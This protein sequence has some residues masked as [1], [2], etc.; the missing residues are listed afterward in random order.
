M[1]ELYMLENLKGEVVW[2][3]DDNPLVWTDLKIAEKQADRRK[4]S[5]AVLADAVAASSH[6]KNSGHREL[7]KMP[8]GAVSL[9]DMKGHLLRGTKL[10]PGEPDE[11]DL[12]DAPKT[13]KEDD[14]KF[15]ISM[16]EGAGK[17]VD[18]RNSTDK[19]KK[20]LEDHQ[21]NEESQRQARRDKDDE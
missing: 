19:L 7:E 15:I 13:A 4:C 3:G 5:V 11:E 6:A 12:E 2:L 8:H 17:K 10:E 21:K 9:R 14:R 16:L 1:T 18:K 20:M